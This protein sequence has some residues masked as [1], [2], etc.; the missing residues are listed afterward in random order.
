MA[1]LIIGAGALAYEQV[2]KK[3]RARKEAR[4]AY[5]EERFSELEKANADRIAAL[6]QNTCFCQ[7][8]DWRGGGCEVHGYVPPANT[9]VSGDVGRTEASQERESKRLDQEYRQ[10][11]RNEP[12]EYL[13]VTENPGGAGREQRNRNLITEGWNGQRPKMDDEEIKR[14]ND[15]RRKRMKASKGYERWF[16]RKWHAPT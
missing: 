10:T 1:S 15:E 13:D 7:Q 8:S 2:Q 5:N 16:G 9:V 14:I 12:P 3:K 11:E 4:V 6:Q